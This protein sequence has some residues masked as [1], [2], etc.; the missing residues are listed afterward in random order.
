MAQGSGTIIKI[1]PAGT[2][3]TFASGLAVPIGLAFEPTTEKLRNAS[4]RAFVQTGDNVLILGFILGGNA[5]ANNAVLARAI[6]PSLGI[7]NSL[8]DPILELHNA[9][10]TVIALNDNWQDTQAAQISATGLAPA[11]PNESA[12]LATLPA[13][14]YTAVARGVAS[15]TGVALVEVYSVQ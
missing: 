10:G 14:N 1:T 6:G 5:L 8:Q 3:S 15:T 4:A 13:G 9:S 2:K 12:I 11:N 7:P